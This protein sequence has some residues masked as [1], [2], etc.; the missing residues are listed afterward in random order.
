M[1]ESS[2]CNES[3]GVTHEERSASCKATQSTGPEKLVEKGARNEHDVKQPAVIDFE[4]GAHL[5]RTCRMC[6]RRPWEATC[7]TSRAL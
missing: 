2:P 4:T 7:G 6:C 1:D 3:Q 5:H